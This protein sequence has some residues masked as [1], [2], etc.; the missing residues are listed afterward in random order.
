MPER[1]IGKSLS[2]KRRKKKE[3]R[4]VS[5]RETSQSYLALDL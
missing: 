5:Q 3:V 4:S 1:V 2:T